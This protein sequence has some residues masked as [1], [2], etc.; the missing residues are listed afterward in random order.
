MCTVGYFVLLKNLFNRSA[1]HAALL[2]PLCFSRLMRNEQKDLAEK[3]S[4]IINN[5][6]DIWSVAL[7]SILTPC[8]Y[9]DEPVGKGKIRH[10]S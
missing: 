6:L 10:N 4:W 9:F 7:L 8:L 2:Y 3:S 1:A 5:L